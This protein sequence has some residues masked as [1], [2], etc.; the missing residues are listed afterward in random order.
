MAG[1]DRLT[2]L[3]SCNDARAM[4]MRAREE[5]IETVWDRLAAQQPQCG[6]CSLGVSCRN[7]SMGP[8]RVDPFKEGPQKGVCGAD[9]DIIV[10]RNLGRTI[11]AGAAAHSDHGRDVLEVFAEL[12]EGRTSG[13]ELRDETKLMALAGELGIETAD[14]ATDEIARDV[15]DA[16]LEDFGT[17]KKAIGFSNR[18]PDPRRERKLERIWTSHCS[19][20]GA[21][22]TARM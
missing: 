3:S 4:I 15:A 20:H 14:R 11:A 10:A 9:A 2:Q 19:S 12:A 5:G 6:Y 8:C 17:R 18:A 16:M 13:Y 22:P 21:S 1:T 7:C